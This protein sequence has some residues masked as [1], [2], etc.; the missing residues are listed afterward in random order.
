[1]T[2]RSDHPSL[3]QVDVTVQFLND[4]RAK[5]RAY[6]ERRRM[7]TTEFR[8]SEPRAQALSVSRRRGQIHDPRQ[9]KLDL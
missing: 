5:Q 7:W 1:M 3:L 8:P 4:A 6:A 9:A 2:E